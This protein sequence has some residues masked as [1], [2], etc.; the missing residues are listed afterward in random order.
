MYTSFPLS[1]SGIPTQ[2]LLSGGSHFLSK[3]VDW[4]WWGRGRGWGRGLCPCR[5]VGVGACPL[6]L[7]TSA[8]LGNSSWCAPSPGTVC[9]TC[10]ACAHNSVLSAVV[11]SALSSAVASPGAPSVPGPTS[12]SFSLPVVLLQQRF[13]EPWLDSRP[14]GARRPC[15]GSPVLSLGNLH[16]RLEHG[17]CGPWTGC[18]EGREAPPGAPVGLA[19]QL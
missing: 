19:V 11:R 9:L 4:E 3:V 18:S 15:L 13:A 7:R 5:G 8:L 14:R 12:G 16:A 17:L 6:L 10:S 2:T 1:K